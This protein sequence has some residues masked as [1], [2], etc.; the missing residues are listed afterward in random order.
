MPRQRRHRP[1]RPSDEELE[2]ALQRLQDFD[3]PD[4]EQP[5]TDRFAAAHG[6]SHSYKGF[7]R[8]GLTED[9]VA[10]LIQPGLADACNIFLAAMRGEDTPGDARLA[11]TLIALAKEFV[12]RGFPQPG[13]R[14]R[15]A[16]L[17]ADLQRI[18]KSASPQPTL[19][20]PSPSTESQT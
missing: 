16:Q 18:Q 7:D 5:W 9:L 19:N 8:L 13:P 15:A 10:R 14:E 17:L 12:L 2:E 6:R 4:R 1:R 11:A 20:T 3:I